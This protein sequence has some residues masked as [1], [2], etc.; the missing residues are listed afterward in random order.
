MAPESE[1]RQ[2][3]W[4][5]RFARHPYFGELGMTSDSQFDFAYDEYNTCIGIEVDWYNTYIM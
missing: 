5:N 3:G 4:Y 2:T 1:D